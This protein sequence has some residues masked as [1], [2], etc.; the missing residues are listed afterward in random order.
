MWQAKSCCC[1]CGHRGDKRENF[2]PLLSY[3]TEK[4]QDD[5]NVPVKKEDGKTDKIENPTHEQLLAI[6]AG[7]SREDLE[8]FVLNNVSEEKI[9]A[10]S[11]ESKGK[12]ANPYEHIICYGTGCNPIT[13]PEEI[14]G[15]G[16]RVELNGLI[17]TPAEVLTLAAFDSGVKRSTMNE[18][19]DFFLPIFISLEHWQKKAFPIFK[20]SIDRIFAHTTKLPPNEYPYPPVQAILILC[21]LMNST[22]LAAEKAGADKRTA[23][24]RFINGY[25]T[26][27]RLLKGVANNFP[28]ASEYADKRIASFIK[29]STY[30]NKDP[31]TGCPNLGEFILLLHI[32]KKYTWNDIALLCM[33]ESDIRRVRWFLKDHPELIQTDRPFPDRYERN[34]AATETSRRLISFQVKFLLISKDVNLN[35]FIDGN[36]P[37]ELLQMMKKLHNEITEIKTWQEYNSFLNAP[38]F[39]NEERNQQLL[40]AIKESAARGYHSLHRRGGGDHDRRYDHGGYRHDNYRNDY[41]GAPYQVRDRDRRF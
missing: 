29:S 19:L 37:E 18:N 6:L 17:E 4:K 36:A 2:F 24:D 40:D 25:F 23:N 27:L 33:E 22:C 35:E 14:F 20:R 34:F 9:R 13:D 16:V 38:T 1:S 41:R 26:I 30:R 32:S 5:K 39:T 31:V 11:Q 12:A 28:G 21:A 7:L 15:F 3:S 8:Q 10:L